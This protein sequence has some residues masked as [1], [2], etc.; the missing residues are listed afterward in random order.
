[1]KISRKGF[2]LG[3]T[4][5]AVLATLVAAHTDAQAQKEKYVSS[6]PPTLSLVAEPS[7]IKA[8][9]DAARVQLT[10]NARSNAGAALRYRWNVNG[11]KL[12]GDGANPS[13]DLAGAAPGVYQAVA[14]VDDGRDLNCVAL[15]SISVIVLDC[16][17]PPPPPPVCPT[18]SISC[19]EAGKENEPGD[20]YRKPQRRYAEHYSELQLDDLWRAHPERSGHA[21]HH[22]GH[23][24]FGGTD[25]SR[26]SGRWRFW[27]AVPRE[28]RSRNPHREQAT[29]V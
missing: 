21:N 29:Q 14:E 26:D 16:P 9:P 23:N 19:P 4:L 1:M 11:G 25:P 27:H 20:V 3:L 13:W 12:S 2:G 5:A 10:A 28:L 8:C 17:P 15:S 7:V 24:R 18:V 22:R 6:G